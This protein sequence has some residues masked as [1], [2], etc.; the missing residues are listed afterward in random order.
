MQ[1]FRIREPGACEIVSLPQPVPQPGE[2]LLRV[3]LIGFC[4]S[5]LT[6]YLGRNPMVSYPRIPG[7]EIAAIIETVTPGVPAEFTVGTAVTVR[8]YSNCGACAA[9][10]H[11]RPHACKANQTLGVQRDGA[12]TDYLAVPWEKL[13][14]APTLSETELALVEPLTVGFHAVERGR[15][16]AADK[17]L[18]FGCGMIG[19]GAIAGAAARGATVMAV[20]IDDAKLAIA[21]EVGAA[22]GINSKAGNLHEAVLALTGGQGADVVIEAVG[23]PLTYRAAIEEVGFTGRV[24]CIGY[25]KD[26]VAFTTKY[27]VQKELDIMGS[28]N[29]TPA[30]F[31]N[32]TR[33][34]AQH[35]F[36]VDQVITRRVTLAE[37]GTALQD[38]AAAPARITKILVNL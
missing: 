4:G 15:V 10:R 23:S 30:D 25:A 9:C 14:L 5:D 27:F 18:V 28:R 33:L 17:V 31:A 12:L 34:L 36:P 19:L 13:V 6:T 11:G 37:A 2:V 24:V 7:H 20:D 1:A 21:R 3:R 22:E 26:D 29:A 35:R 32:V 8:P 38:W 16:E